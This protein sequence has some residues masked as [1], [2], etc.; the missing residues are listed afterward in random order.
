MKKTV[1][2][3]T[4]NRITMYVLYSFLAAVFYFFSYEYTAFGPEIGFIIVVLAFLKDI[5]DSYFISRGEEPSLYRYVE[6][7]PFNFILVLFIFGLGYTEAADLQ[8]FQVSAEGIATLATIEFV[9]DLYQDLETE[10]KFK[11]S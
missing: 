2:G 6:H 9:L 3:L 5:V 8:L 10:R 11:R 4:E 7:N 1:Y